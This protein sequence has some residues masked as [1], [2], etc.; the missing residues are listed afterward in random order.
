MVAQ[1]Q[2]L[3]RQ[4]QQQQHTVAPKVYFRHMRVYVR[5]FMCVPQFTIKSLPRFLKLKGFAQY[6]LLRFN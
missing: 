3:L 4:Q 2:Q 1:Q 6:N 5:T